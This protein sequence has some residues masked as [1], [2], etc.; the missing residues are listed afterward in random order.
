MGYELEEK[1]DKCI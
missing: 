1:S